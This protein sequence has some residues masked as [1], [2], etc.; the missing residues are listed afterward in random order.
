MKIGCSASW[1]RGGRLRGLEPY[2]TS[3][4]TLQEM[5]SPA[6]SVAS[7]LCSGLDVVAPH[8]ECLAGCRGVP[9]ARRTRVAD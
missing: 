2:T 6:S 9:A 7:Q 3:P 8:P 5:T 1:K 4:Y